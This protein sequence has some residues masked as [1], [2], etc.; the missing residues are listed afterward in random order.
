MKRFALVI[1]L[2]FFGAALH[3]QAVDSSAINRV[4]SYRSFLSTV[5]KA[6]GIR[7]KLK[8]LY[9]S[10]G[11]FYFSFQISNHSPLSYPVDFI[12]FYI[13]DRLSGKRSSVQELEM[14]PI[15]KDTLSC[16]HPG[17]DRDFM[18]VVPQFT[19]PN[20]QECL[21]EIFEQSGGRNLT[22]KILNRDLYRAKPL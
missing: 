18:I 20:A 22:L 16:V 4:K 7:L 1:L 6:Y 8:G 9:V 2:M 5:S 3:A 15:Y 14:V 21:L 13:H 19:I 10:R 12:H 17:V 11:Q